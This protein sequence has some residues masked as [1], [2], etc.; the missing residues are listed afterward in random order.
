MNETGEGPGGRGREI[1]GERL[2]I[3]HLEGG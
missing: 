2:M 1:D 3:E